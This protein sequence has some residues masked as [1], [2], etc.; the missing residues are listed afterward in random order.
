MRP[1]LVSGNNGLEVIVEL[2]TRYIVAKIPAL[3]K[4]DK[5]TQEAHKTGY[6]TDG[7][8]IPIIEI[9]RGAKQQ[10]A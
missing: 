5:T 4:H 9:N 7:W 1:D 6:K 3:Q 8:P 10:D 2:I